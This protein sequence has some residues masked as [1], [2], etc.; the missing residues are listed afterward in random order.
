MREFSKNMG[1]RWHYKGE[2][3]TREKKEKKNITIITIDKVPL[4]LH[5][6]KSDAGKNRI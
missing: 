6:E 4:T 1:L 3:W 5:V 2:N